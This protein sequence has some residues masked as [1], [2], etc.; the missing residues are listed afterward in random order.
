VQRGLTLEHRVRL[1]TNDPVVHET[2]SPLEEPDRQLGLGAKCAV[3]LN[4]G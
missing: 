2:V 4:V 1:A 3:G